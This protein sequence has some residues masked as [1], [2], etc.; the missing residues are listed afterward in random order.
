MICVKVSGGLGNQLFQYA[1]GRAIAKD[2]NEE[3]F[4]DISDYSVS[5]NIRKFE[6]GNFKTSNYR[7]ISS[8]KVAGSLYFRYP[9]ITFLFFAFCNYFFNRIK[10]IEE[11]AIDEIKYN[12]KDGGLYYYN[13]YWQS[14]K[15]FKSV[16]TE[17]KEELELKFSPDL[18]MRTIFKENKTIVIQIRRGDYLK[19]AKDSSGRDLVLPIDYYKRALLGIENF[20]SYK[21]FI[22][23]DEPGRISQEWTDLPENAIICAND[24]YLDFWMICNSD[25]AIISNSSFGWWGAYLNKKADKK[26][27]IPQYWFGRYEKKWLPEGIY[28]ENWNVIAQEV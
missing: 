18:K 8:R 25:I 23:S 1:F 6:L 10:V 7:I 5:G 3:L 21:I 24:H 14:E 22:M 19:Y 27:F 15:Y 17:I 9:S 16:L 12:N 28:V 26:I 20:K 2:N 13:G 11:S 4:I